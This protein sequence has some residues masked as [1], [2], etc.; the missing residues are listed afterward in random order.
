MKYIF[1]DIE[2]AN[3]FG[4]NGKICSFGY[5]ITDRF[6][7]VLEKEDIVINP[8]APF[9][10]GRKGKD[11]IKLAYS[12]E[13]FKNAPDFQ[14]FYRMIKSI[15]SRKDSLIFGY[16]SENDENFLRSECERYILP[17]INFKS[18]DVQKLLRLEFHMKNSIS[19]SSA[20]SLFG[21]C[22]RQELHKSD[23]DSLMTA[24][25]LKNLCIKFRTSPE[26][27]IE[28]YPQSET[29]LR[30][31]DVILKKL[32]GKYIREYKLGDHSNNAEYGSDNYLCVRRFIYNVKP[33]N[34]SI[35]ESF[36]KKKVLIYPGYIYKNYRE[37]VKLIQLIANRGGTVTER[38]HECDFFL[39]LIDYDEFGNKNVKPAEIE[40]LQNQCKKVVF[41]SVDEFVEMLGI[42]YPE[43][44]K[45]TAPDISYLI[46]DKY[47]VH[48]SKPRRP[49]KKRR[50]RSKSKRKTPKQTKDS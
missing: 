24:E 39:Y 5:V 17:C 44:M 12:K 38:L 36:L 48:I 4:G 25:V 47:E 8:K 50:A 20:E 46:D 26:A 1:F 9:M 28:K 19:L 42:P 31:Y 11:F 45:L 14:R 15:L 29:E 32:E 30:D 41:L 16:A 40:Q 18:Y 6:F 10:L 34:S 37:T 21:V 13:E 23:D 43:F 22:N 27:L 33:S 3:C 35:L 7:N 2:C 49:F